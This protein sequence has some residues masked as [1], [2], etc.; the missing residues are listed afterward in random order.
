MVQRKMIFEAA[1][2]LASGL[3]MAQGEAVDV[4]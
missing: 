4:R 3:A 1:A 2:E